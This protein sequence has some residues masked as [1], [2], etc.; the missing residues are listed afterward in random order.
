MGFF[1]DPEAIRQA[2]ARKARRMHYEQEVID[3]FCSRENLDKIVAFVKNELRSEFI[4]SEG[5]R[6]SSYTVMLGLAPKS[7]VWN[8]HLIRGSERCRKALEQALK[9]IDP[10]LSGVTMRDEYEGC[11]IS[12]ELKF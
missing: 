7:G 9:E 10:S 8:D 1:D 6:Q 4:N 3:N 2:E 11:G 12:L 5:A